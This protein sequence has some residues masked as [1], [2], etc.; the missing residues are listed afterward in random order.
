MSQEVMRLLDVARTSAWFSEVKGAVQELERLGT[1]EAQEALV[2]FRAQPSRPLKWVEE[3]FDDINASGNPVNHRYVEHWEYSSALGQQPCDD[4]RGAVAAK[5]REEQRLSEAS[6][7]R[8][9]EWQSEAAVYLG[10]LSSDREEDGARLAAFCCAEKQRLLFNRRGD[11]DHEI[12]QALATYMRSEHAQRPAIRAL[13]EGLSGAEG[14]LFLTSLC[15]KVGAD[16][17]ATSILEG[18]LKDLRT[19]FLMTLFCDYWAQIAPLREQ[20]RLRL[21]QKDLAEVAGA[22]LQVIERNVLSEAAG[23]ATDLLGGCGEAAIPAIRQLLNHKGAARRGRG[24]AAARLLA[25]DVS[26]NLDRNG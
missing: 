19:G 16:P 22:A 21:M 23:R 3:A 7:A 1:A 6:A 10:L 11:T 4:E 24:L 14:E 8:W 5:A 9:R 25:P 15:F 13:R 12:Y 26:A 18:L 20:V 2:T 17:K